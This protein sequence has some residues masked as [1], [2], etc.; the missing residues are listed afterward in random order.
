MKPYQGPLFVAVVRVSP[1]DSV[2]VEQLETPGSDAIGEIL[3]GPQAEL[4]RL[5]VRRNQHQ[6]K[7]GRRYRVEVSRQ[8]KDSR[9]HVQELPRT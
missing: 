5:L 3:Q 9:I 7:A 2:T 6:F 8:G 4:V 1:G